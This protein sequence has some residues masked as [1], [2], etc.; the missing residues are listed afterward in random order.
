LRIKRL[1]DEQYTETPFYGIRKMTHYLQDDKEENVNHK[2]VARLM[3]EMGI[4][5]IYPKPN[6]SRP[7]AGHK[8]YPY[9]LNGLAITRPNQVWGTDITY[10]PLSQ[11]FAYLVAIL[12]WFSRYVVSWTLSVT[13]DVS[14]CLEALDEAIR[15]HGRPDI[16]NSDQG[17]QFTCPE[18]T[19]RV[20]A[21]KI[22]MSMDGRGRCMDNIFTERLWRSV[23]YED[24]YLK[25]Y[26]AVPVARAGLG[27][28]FEFY[29]HRRRHQSLD[30]LTPAKV[31][32]G[33]SRWN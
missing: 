7:F 12:D 2:R 4:E 17:V 14:F 9:L 25:D 32:A 26:D 20:E 15:C 33:G 27:G 18:F 21:E 11:G 31:Y 6:L 5:A 24:V 1:I 30:Y 28:Y 10:I 29:N 13:L 3:R 16:L 23:K 8:K 22:R 19:G